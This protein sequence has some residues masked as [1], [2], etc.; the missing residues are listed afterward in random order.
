LSALKKL[1]VAVLE[2]EEE[3]KCYAGKVKGEMISLD[4]PSVG[5]TENVMLT[6]VLANGKTE[7]RNS[8]REPEIVDLMNFLNSMG[9]KVYG[10]GTSTILIEG[11]KELHGTVYKPMPDRIEAGT[12]MMIGALLGNNLKIRNVNVTH[13]SEVINV[14]KKIGVEI[15]EKENEVIVSKGNNYKKKRLLLE[16]YCCVVLEH[17]FTYHIILT[18]VAVWESNFS[19]RA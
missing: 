19:R 1:G 7:I 16:N 8:A 3:I 15:I 10:A 17:P 12:F 14:L 2:E 6:A 18:I 4:F 11:V 5:A 13:L 9:A